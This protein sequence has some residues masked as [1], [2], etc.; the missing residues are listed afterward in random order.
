MRSDG[1]SFAITS[2]NV[3]II[4]LVLDLPDGLFDAAVIDHSPGSLFTTM[5]QS[6]RTIALMFAAAHT[7]AISMLR[8]SRRRTSLLYPTVDCP[9]TYTTKP[10]QIDPI[11]DA[12]VRQ[13]ASSPSCPQITQL[14]VLAII[15]CVC[16]PREQPETE[17]L[18]PVRVPLRVLVYE[19]RHRC[20][21]GP[22]VCQHPQGIG[23]RV[24]TTFPT[25]GL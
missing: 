2:P 16:G 1:C 9:F 12:H 22:S 10:S 25:F 11:S 14:I 17:Q 23:S 21:G 19:V 7:W 20:S 18:C 3:R 24:N 4:G 6:S 5:Y 13:V 8:S 15:T